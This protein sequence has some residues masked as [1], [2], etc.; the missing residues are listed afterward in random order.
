MSDHNFDRTET[1]VFA[2]DAMTPTEAA[3]FRAAMTH[4]EVARAEATE[5]TDTAIRLG[6]SLAPVAPPASLRASILDAIDTLPQQPAAKSAVGP[7]EAE[8]R[9]RWTR[10][11]VAAIAAA[12]AAVALIA[13]GIAVGT[14]LATNS[15]T[16]ISAQAASIQNAADVRTR[17]VSI[18]GG[19]TAKLAWSRKE[20]RADIRV[21]ALPELASGKTYELWYIRGSKAIPA[22]TFDPDADGSAT[23]ILTGTYR[24]GDVIGLTVEPAGGSLKPTTAPILATATA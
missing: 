19:G 9:R 11:P 22:G 5:L 8:A 17:T 10:R 12:A 2:L 13:G 7:R 21:T 16:S 4:D 14:S 23:A 18:A 6:L 24:V 1:G 15:S 3:D 20:A